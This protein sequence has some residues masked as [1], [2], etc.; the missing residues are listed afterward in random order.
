MV[1]Y[2]FTLENFEYFL[3]V[4]SY[5]ILLIKCLDEGFYDKIPAIC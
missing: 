4:K 1:N 3:L 5:G 2:V